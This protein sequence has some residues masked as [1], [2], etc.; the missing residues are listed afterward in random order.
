MQIS[1]WT[2]LADQHCLIFSSSRSKPDD[3]TMKQKANSHPVTRSQLPLF[4]CD[5]ITGINDTYS[6]A[7]RQAR[8]TDIQS[9]QGWSLLSSSCQRPLEGAIS[10]ENQW[11]DMA[12]HTQTISSLLLDSKPTLHYFWL[13]GIVNCKRVCVCVCTVAT[14][15]RVH[16]IL[17]KQGHHT[18][19]SSH[20]LIHSI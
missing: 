8:Q 3:I 19:H 1:C 2:L 17:N 16:I 20:S 4:W 7:L 13:W 12:A 10:I 11:S 18:E 6:T 14:V 5:Y 9:V 15:W